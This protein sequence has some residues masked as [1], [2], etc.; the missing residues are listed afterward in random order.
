MP[1]AAEIC[2][3]V[4]LQR[5]T[6]KEYQAVVLPA[7]ADNLNLSFADDLLEAEVAK[8]VPNALWQHMKFDWKAIDDFAKAI[9]HKIPDPQN[10]RPRKLTR[11]ILEDI[12]GRPLDL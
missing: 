1:E 12:L 5:L 2:T 10:G 3:R 4:V 7:L 8:R 6:K 11:A 9:K